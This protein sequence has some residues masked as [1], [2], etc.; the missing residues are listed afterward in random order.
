MKAN[1]EVM[2]AVR[3]SGKQN[4]KI[5]SDNKLEELIEQ[6]LFSQTEIFKKFTEDKDFER[7]YKDFIFETLVDANKQIG[8]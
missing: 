7:R 5:A 2:D 8:V 4:A 1:K 6:Y 3:Y